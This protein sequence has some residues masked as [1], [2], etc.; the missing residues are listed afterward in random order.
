MDWLDPAKVKAWLRKATG[1]EAEQSLLP[2]DPRVI[3]RMAME[4]FVRAV[5]KDEYEYCDHAEVAR[6]IV[7]ALDERI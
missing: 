6:I 1:P 3:A 5:A 7:E 4:Q 2:S